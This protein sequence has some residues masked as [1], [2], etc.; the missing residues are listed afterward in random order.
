MLH[1]GMRH[2]F[3]RF[4][5]YAAASM[6]VG[7]TAAAIVHGEF[8]AM[9][10]VFWIGFAATFV[11]LIVGPILSLWW[12]RTRRLGDFVTRCG[13]VALL[14]IPASFVGSRAVVAVELWNAKRYVT[15]QVIPRLEAHRR[16]HGAYPKTMKVPDDAPW[17][18][19]RFTY[20]SD[21]RQ[22]SMGVWD[23]GVCGRVTSYWSTARQWHQTYDP[24]YY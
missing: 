9:L 10:K 2:K 24:C 13:I 19:H 20:H 23:P 18:V 21:G 5:A 12:Q 22:Y 17:L 7:T 4:A 11:L 16:S 14:A 3:R 8:H 15:A 1:E 6:A